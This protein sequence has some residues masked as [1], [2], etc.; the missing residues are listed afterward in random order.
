MK[1]SFPFFPLLVPLVFLLPACDFIE[2]VGELDEPS[3]L[4]EPAKLETRRL[5]PE[6]CG[7]SS[8]FLSLD[9][10]DFRVTADGGLGQFLMQGLLVSETEEAPFSGR[11]IES[12]YLVVEEDEAA[13]D[14]PNVLAFNYYSDLVEAGNTINKM[15]DGKLYLRLGVLEDGNLKSSAYFSE[16]SETALLEAL[17]QQSFITLLILSPTYLGQGADEYTVYPCAIEVL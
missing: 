9:N 6:L 14:D 7:D 11:S 16:E 8:A 17:N 3:E 5:N 4:D 13:L 15:K 12:V 10:E 2:N 1:T